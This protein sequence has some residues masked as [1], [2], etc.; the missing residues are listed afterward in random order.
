VV[1]HRDT[2]ARQCDAADAYTNMN[3]GN[4]ND[5]VSSAHPFARGSVAQGDPMM[6]PGECYDAKTLE[7]MTRVL[8]SA[9][10]DVEPLIRGR[11]LDYVALRTVMSV[12]IMASVRDGHLDPDHLKRVALGAIAHVVEGSGRGPGFE[13]S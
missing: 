6:F 8:E 7:L 5:G 2:A 9:W 12:R 3:A 1:E 11:N 10:H 13:A 4:P